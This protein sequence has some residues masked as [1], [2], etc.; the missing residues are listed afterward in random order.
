MEKQ[1]VYGVQTRDLSIDILKG[2]GIILVVIGHAGCPQWL[3]NIIFSF[4]MPLFFIAS[5]FFFNDSYLDDKTQF[6]KRRIKRLYIPFVK[7]SLIFLLLHNLFFFIGI[8]NDQYGNQNGLVSSQYSIKEILQHAFNIVTRMCDYEIF[9]LG[10]YWFMRALFVGSIM[11]C[12]F[13]WIIRKITIR[14][15]VAIGIA[16]VT[17][18]LIAGG[19]SYF[20][21]QIP[22]YPQG[23]F[24]DF[25]A[26]SFIGV[27]YFLKINQSHI[28]AK[29]AVFSCIVCLT[30]AVLHPA[31]MSILSSVDN[32]LIITLSGI[33]GT[34]AVFFLCKRYVRYN[35]VGN[36][37]AYVG[38]RS[39]YV[40]TFHI[41]MFKPAAL[42][43]TFIYH[44]EWKAI[45]SHI[46]ILPIANNWYWIVYSVSSLILSLLVERIL[47][48]IPKQSLHL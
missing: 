35:R 33:S 13:S 28:S 30:C 7:W 21:F 12:V 36:A 45:G 8:L 17:T 11:L 38:K 27:G 40:L 47:N 34:I 43:Y 22:H 39:F 3:R 6:I 4:H 16:I 42:L 37:L 10:A 19:I 41:L 2:I 31:K 20:G 25:M 26:V 18:W 29:I 1:I 15:D 46:V 32:W 14:T 44:L 48:N 23:G 9:T 24:R 5:G